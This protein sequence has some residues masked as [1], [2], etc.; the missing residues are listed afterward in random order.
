M[1]KG[2]ATVVTIMATGG[3]GVLSV[4]SAGCGLFGSGP[5]AQRRATAVKK[6]GAHRP[7]GGGKRVTID[8]AASPITQT[9]T[10]RTMIRAFEASHPNLRVKL[11]TMSTNT[12]TTRT[13]LSTEIEG[14]SATPDVYMGDVIWPAQFAHSGLAVNLSKYL[15]HGFW[16]RF[17]PGLVTGASYRGRVYAAP[18]FMDAGFL[19]YRKDLLKK[20]GLPVPRTWQQLASDAKTLQAKHLVRY[21]YVWEGAAYEGLTCDLMEFLADSGAK[22]LNSAGT[23]VVLN[24]PRAISAVTFMRSLI[25]RGISPAAVS[26]YQE[27]DAMNTF[28]AGDAAFMRNWDYAWSNSQTPG[29]K[30]VGKVGVE[31]MP[32]FAG[33]KQPGYSCIGGWDLYVNPHTRHLQQA[34]TFIRWMTSAPAQRILAKKYSEVP[35]NYA[36]QKESSVRKK[37]P[38]LRIVARVRLVSRPSSTPLYPQL[39]QALYQNVNAALTGQIAPTTAITRASREISADLAGRGL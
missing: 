36:V 19:Y 6:P 5:A 22:V 38:V 29:T 10:R 37:N 34:L 28:D 12:D 21:G 33:A 24:S 39:S 32:A 8:W 20:A 35:T 14:G 27:P 17:A 31:P 7:P 1:T 2:K 23:K 4:V 11:I 30:V 9:G 16:S 18:F 3:I 13:T 26:T 25:T 15:P